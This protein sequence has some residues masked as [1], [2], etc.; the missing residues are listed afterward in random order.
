M[1]NVSRDSTCGKCRAILNR[2]SLG[3][4]GLR[5]T[6]EKFKEELEWLTWLLETNQVDLLSRMAGTDSTT[7]KLFIKP[8]HIEGKLGQ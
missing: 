7:T 8:I 5:V 1:E 2:F 3:L 6:S 4:A